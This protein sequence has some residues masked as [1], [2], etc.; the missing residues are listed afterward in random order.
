MGTQGE[1]GHILNGVQTSGTQGNQIVSRLRQ[2]IAG[3]ISR[4][5]VFSKLR[6]ELTYPLL[7]YWDCI[8]YLAGIVSNDDPCRQWLDLHSCILLSN[9]HVLGR[10]YFGFVWWTSSAATGKFCKEEYNV[11]KNSN[12]I[13]VS[14][15]PVSY[16]KSVLF[17][18]LLAFSLHLTDWCFH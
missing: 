6:T 8:S 16:G 13:T 9:K 1:T 2:G 11:I 7:W 12:W 4:L 3:E 10:E 14:Q 5:T 17:K 15:E 18:I